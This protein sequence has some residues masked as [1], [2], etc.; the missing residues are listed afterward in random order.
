M[1]LWFI[2][3]TVYLLYYTFLYDDLGGEKYIVQKINVGM[4]TLGCDKNRVDA[5][6]MLGVLSDDEYEIVN[7]ED[8]ADVIIVNT[9]AFIDSAKQESID[10]IL[11]M[12]KKKETGQCKIL[13]ASGCL[14][15]RYS[16]ELLSEI[17]ELDAVVGVGNYMEIGS[18][19][20]KLINDNVR[21]NKADNV[22]YNVDFKGRRVLT[23]PQ[24]TAYLKIA[25]GCSNNCSYCIIPKLRGKYRSRSMENIIDEVNQL[26]YNGTKEIILVAQDIT[27]YGIDL[28]GGKKKLP[29]LL[30]GISK[31][32][33]IEWI[34][35]LY[36]YPEDIDDRLIDE[37]AHNEKVCKYIDIPMQHINDTILKRMRRASTSAGIKNLIG[38]LREKVPGI[39]IRTSLIVGFPGESD[40]QFNELYDFLKEYKLDRVGIFE[41]S[42]E[43]GTDAALM[44]QQIDERVKGLRQKKLASLQRRI[45]RD[46]N[47]QRIGKT[48]KVL[49]EGVEDDG[50][51]YGRTYA[52]A[53][54]IDGMVYIKTPCRIGEFVDVKITG[55][56]DYDL[57]GDVT[58]EPCK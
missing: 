54:E 18:I 1:N 31:V 15:Q 33:G 50:T 44:M 58:C 14:A 22:N 21:I 56:L 52:D 30:K 24:Y 42:Q 38:K 51:S 12:A 40:E 10:T 7:D 9:C 5:E 3:D 29:D 13:I 25:E 17:P 26:A 35:L 27:K 19:I 23:T 36:C 2:F 55:A 49:V 6:L 46:K 8:Q 16:S 43:E 47:K 37:I 32:Q 45:S 20:R 41:Y 53:P 11:E 34:R 4:V 57:I 48:M 39:V 28:Y